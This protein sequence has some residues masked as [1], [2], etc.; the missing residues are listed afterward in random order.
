MSRASIASMSRYFYGIKTDPY[1]SCFVINVYRIW[2]HTLG[3]S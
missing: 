3:A 2:R 1:A